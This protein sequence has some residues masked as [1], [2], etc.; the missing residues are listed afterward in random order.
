[1]Y[2]TRRNLSARRP[3]GMHRLAGLAGYDEVGNWIPEVDEVGNPILSFTTQDTLQNKYITPAQTQAIAEIGPT[4]AVETG[5][6]PPIAL[7]P[8]S[9]PPNVFYGLEYV[10]PPGTPLPTFGYSGGPASRGAV[11]V[12]IDASGGGYITPGMAHDNVGGDPGFRNPLTDLHRLGISDDELGRLATQAANDGASI[13]PMSA[14]D[15]AVF[16]ANTM[17]LAAQAHPDLEAQIRP[18]MPTPDEFASSIAYAQAQQRMNSDDYGI[19]V[20]AVLGAGIGALAISGAGLIAGASQVAGETAT[21]TTAAQAASAIDPATLNAIASGWES[22]TATSSLQS[23]ALSAAAGDAGAASALTAAVGETSAAAMIS[24]ATTLLASA[25]YAPAGAE[26]TAAELYGGSDIGTGAAEDIATG[27]LGPGGY[28]GTELTSTASDLQSVLD[29]VQTPET[30]SMPG[31]AGGGAPTPSGTSLLQQAGT[32]AKTGAGI[33]STAEAVWKAFTGA[34]APTTTPT[35]VATR[36]PAAAP[37]LAGSSPLLLL[38]LLGAGAGA[39]IAAQRKK[40]K[41]PH[42]HHAAGHAR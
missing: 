33:L 32:L 37:A 3:I 21:I 24:D 1:M 6:I 40:H 18:L 19:Y 17:T 10:L 25:G 42:P 12:Y 4:A 22:A 11:G 36:A 34:P 14:Y 26:L 9:A 30:P 13:R 41:G 38:L 20:M 2:L 8:E 27:A 35:L 5:V 23:I 39:L 31:G 29:N 28:A 7:L 16:Y 15:W